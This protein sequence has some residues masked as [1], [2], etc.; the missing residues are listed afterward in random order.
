LVYLG[1]VTF[2]QP[3]RFV[4]WTEP[5]AVAAKL[6]DGVRLELSK[7]EGRAR[8]GRILTIV[9]VLVTVTAIGASFQ[10]AN[11]S[12][13][14]KAEVIYLRDPGVALLARVCDQLETPAA[15][16]GK[17]SFEGELVVISFDAT[18]CTEE[19]KTVKV[20]RASFLGTASPP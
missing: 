18:E 7:I 2:A 14:Q 20:A 9:A 11:S 3:D 19:T 5:G 8:W 15:A 13:E 1:A 17:V 10:D 16:I 4:N 12:S 6:I